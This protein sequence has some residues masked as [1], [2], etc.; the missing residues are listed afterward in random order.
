MMNQVSLLIV[1]SNM[2]LWKTFHIVWTKSISLKELSQREY[3][4]ERTK[5]LPFLVDELN[6]SSTHT[7]MVEGFVLSSLRS[8]HPTYI[9]CQKKRA[10]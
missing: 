10:K 2:T 5:L 1:T 7:G 4:T 8:T 3:D 6:T 9:S